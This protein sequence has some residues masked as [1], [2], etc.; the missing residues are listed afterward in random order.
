MHR[1]SIGDMLLAT[2][3]Y[4]AVKL[5]Y[6]DSKLIV[7]TSYAGYEMLYGNPYIDELVAYQK[8]EPI[9]QQVRI[10]KI[11]WQSDVALIMDIHHRNAVYAFLAGIPHR[12]GWGEGF[13]NQKP[14]C[15]ED[16]HYEAWYYMGYAAAIDA[17]S[18]DIRLEP[19]RPTQEERGRMR[20]MVAA[21][22]EADQ[23]IVVI[24]PYSLSPLKDWAAEKYREIMRRFHQEKWTVVALGGVNEVERIEK[25]FPMAV[26]MAGKCNLREA[27]ELIAL[28]DLQISGCT[29]MLHVCA[30]TNT[31]SIAIYGPTNPD[32]WAPQQNCHVIT[33]R[34]PCSPCYGKETVC[35][36]KKC[37][38]AITVEDVWAEVKPYL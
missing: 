33:K 20:A 2:P 7:V 17:Y 19:L 10:L 24:V 9:W 13:I 8:E 27:A 18:D 38:Q 15:L 32:Q 29:A 5:R 16:H 31:P 4:R 26:N 14:E 22:K 1:A 36:D 30:T 12:I 25:E 37:L 21:I 23:K 28:A 6:P 3:T 34:F 11:F 35:K